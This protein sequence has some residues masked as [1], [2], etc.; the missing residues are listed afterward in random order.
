MSR[1]VGGTV[2]TEGSVPWQASFT[3]WTFSLVEFFFIV[4]LVLQ[5]LTQASLTVS[6]TNVFCGASV[7]TDRHLVTAAHCLAGQ[8]KKTVTSR[9]EKTEKKMQKKNNLSFFGFFS[10]VQTGVLDMVGIHL[11]IRIVHI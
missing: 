9:K 7:V 5:C 3:S 4:L 11:Q 1:I 2:A 8:N 6:G 10:G